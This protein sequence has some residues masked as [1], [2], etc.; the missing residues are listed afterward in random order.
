M[1]SIQYCKMGQGHRAVKKIEFSIFDFDSHH[2]PTSFENEMV[3][4]AQGGK[5]KQRDGN[6]DATLTERW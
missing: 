3:I 6:C 4:V 1:Y 5:S 2:I